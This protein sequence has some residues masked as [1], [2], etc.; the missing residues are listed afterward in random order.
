VQHAVMYG[1]ISDLHGRV[2]SIP[3]E[4]LL[5]S[6]RSILQV[7]QFRLSCITGGADWWRSTVLQNCW[8]DLQSVTAGSLR[9]ITCMVGCT[10]WQ[11]TILWGAGVSSAVTVLVGASVAGRIM[12]RCAVFWLA[13][14]MVVIDSIPYQG[15]G[16]LEEQHCLWVSV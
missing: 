6:L 10:G 16:G 15:S 9:S 8:T 5:H 12:F 2:C 3:A 7:L 11:P 14:V 1:L 13:I 4:I